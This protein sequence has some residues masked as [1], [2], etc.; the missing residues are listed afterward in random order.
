MTLLWISSQCIAFRRNRSTKE[1]N[2]TSYCLTI[3]AD[4]MMTAANLQFLQQRISLSAASV[5]ASQTR[6]IKK[7]NIIWHIPLTRLCFI[8]IL[9]TR[10]A[11]L[12]PVH[13]L[14]KSLIFRF[15]SENK[16]IL[17]SIGNFKLTIY[18]QQ[19]NKITEQ[20]IVF[21]LKFQHGE[22]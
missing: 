4:F 9:Q 8:F 1:R 11:V 10:Y 12:K 17:P 15:I 20:N 22:V 2:V 5:S 18:T 19:I 21:V 14:C 7:W 13:R 3:T 6:C 16:H